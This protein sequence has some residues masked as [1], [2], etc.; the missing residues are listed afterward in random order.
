ML[1]GEHVDIQRDYVVAQSRWLYVPGQGWVYTPAGTY[2]S[3]MD[4]TFDARLADPDF[5][6]PPGLPP[7]AQTSTSQ[8]GIWEMISWSRSG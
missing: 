3:E 7:Q 8:G 1:A 2:H 5:T 6:P 4:V